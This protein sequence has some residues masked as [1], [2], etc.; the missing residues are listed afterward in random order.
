MDV[1]IPEVPPEYDSYRE[2][3]RSF[4]AAKR[5]HFEGK[6]RAGARVLESERDLAEMRRWIR[7]FYDSGYLL[8]RYDPETDQD[9]SDADPFKSRIV[10]EELARVGVATGLGNGLVAGALRRFGNAEQRRKYIPPLERGD[11]IWTQLFSEPNA[12]SDLASLQTRA[13][14]EGD[15]YVVDGQKVWSTY[16][17]SADYGYL[18]ARTNPDEERHGGISAFIFDMKSPGV[19]ARPLREMTGTSDFCE[20]FM[21]SVSVPAENII[22]EPGQGWQIATF[23]LAN[24][25][26]GLG[27]GGGGRTDPIAD[28]V[29]LARGEQ[30]GGRPAIEDSTLRQ[31]IGRL[32]ASSRILRNLGYAIQTRGLRGESTRTDAPLSKIFFS[33]L[34][35]ETAEC[36]LA[37]QGARSVLVE[38]E[39]LSVDDGRWQD[40]F[41]YAR[42]YTIA[43]GS[44][45]VLRNVIAERGLELPRERRG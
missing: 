23:S 43:G 32:C 25:R 20:V 12:G 30:R 24:E 10:R 29:E 19:E 7:D 16:A 31:E 42:A 37:I 14:C 22:G 36:G 33:E 35:L 5:P 2:E 8:R 38:G 13:R 28:L 40:A 17:E 44:N 18:L 6:Q 9:R 11:H 15:H 21:N 34:N 4:I 45:E 26:G 27:G 39:P 41:L 1:K 3:V